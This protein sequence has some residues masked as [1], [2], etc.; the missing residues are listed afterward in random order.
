MIAKVCLTAVCFA[1]LLIAFAD[2]MIP[3]QSR[4]E[5]LSSLDAAEDRRI[6]DAVSKYCQIARNGDEELILSVVAH[7]PHA[8]WI[9]PEKFPDVTDTHNT[10]KM[11]TE[12]S[13]ALMAA[14]PIDNS[15]LAKMNFNGV[16][17]Y[18][19]RAFKGR[20]ELPF[21]R[22]RAIRVNGAYARVNVV[23]DS[24]LGDLSTEFLLAKSPDGW[25]VFKISYR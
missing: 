7:T 18:T 12:N 13:N 17:Q 9:D 24:K 11:S 25:K 14:D 5:T 10:E 21:R 16:S 23:L 19:V 20:I 1:G 6:L 22:I 4:L 3:S 15:D 2:S 8:Y